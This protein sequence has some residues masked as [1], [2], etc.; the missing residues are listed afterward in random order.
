M[1]QPLQRLRRQE[2]GD[3]SVEAGGAGVDVG[4][5]SLTAPAD[6]LLFRGVTHFQNDIQALGLDVYKRQVWWEEGLTLIFA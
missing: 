3:G 5:R 1:F 2:A 6:V 4:E